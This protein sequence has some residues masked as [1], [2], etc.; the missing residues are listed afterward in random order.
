M[1]YF[2]DKALLIFISIDS[3]QKTQTNIVQKEF[4]LVN[5]TIMKIYLHS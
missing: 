1:E 5:P 2:S 4:I 3:I